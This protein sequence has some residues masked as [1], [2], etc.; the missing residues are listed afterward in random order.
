[1]RNELH[2]EKFSKDIIEVSLV[3]LFFEKPPCLDPNST[4]KCVV[5]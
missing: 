5:W 2:Y 1:M 4:K 3:Y